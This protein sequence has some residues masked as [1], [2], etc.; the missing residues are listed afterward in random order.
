MIED[1]NSTPTRQPQVDYG[2]IWFD[3]VACLEGFGN[4]TTKFHELDLVHLL[5][6]RAEP[7][8]NQIGIVQ[9]QNRKKPVRPHRTTWVR[10][11]ICAASR[12]TC[13][14]ARAIRIMRAVDFFAARVEPAG[15]GRIGTGQ[16]SS[17]AMVTGTLRRCVFFFMAQR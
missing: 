11:K 16:F 2:Y 15:A 9:E 8:P 12:R 10:A 17:S 3:G 1:L 6:E 5:H 7:G 13:S 14:L 4:I